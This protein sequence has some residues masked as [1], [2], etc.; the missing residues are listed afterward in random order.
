MSFETVD[1]SKRYGTR[2]VVDGVSLKVDRGEIVG[3]LGPNGAGKTTTF[4]MCVGLVRPNGGQV[5]L[6]D[7]DVTHMAMHRRARNGIGYLA[8]EPSLFRKLSVEDNLRLILEMQ[9][10]SRAEREKRINEL[11]ER[12]GITHI[13]NQQGYMLS[14]GERRR[15]EIARALATEP[16]FILLDEPFTGV[17][18][19]ALDDIQQV[20]AHLRGDG[21]GILL[22]DHSVRETLKITDRAY[23]MY[24]GKILTQGPSSELPNDP[25]AREFYFGERFSM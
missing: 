7:R 1:L 8:Q 17:D 12:F 21:I 5:K 2:A 14:G 22:T 13:R 23:I 24:E 16:S 6:D 4:Y 18:P 15:V 9:P 3:L 20:V 10:L 11:L 19:I 25:V